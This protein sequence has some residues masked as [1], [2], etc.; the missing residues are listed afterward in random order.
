MS[1]DVIALLNTCRIRK[2]VCFG[3]TP[4]ILAM[5][6]FFGQHLFPGVVF[7]EPLSSNRLCR[8]AD[9]LRTNDGCWG[10]DRLARNLPEAGTFKVA[11]GFSVGMT[12]IP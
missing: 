12:A 5:P 10:R 4:S 11:R 2:E 3:S 6:S 1:T 9:N 8:H 7:A